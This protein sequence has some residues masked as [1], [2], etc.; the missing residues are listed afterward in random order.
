MKTVFASG[1]HFYTIELYGVVGV[2]MVIEALE[3]EGGVHA[4]GRRYG[5]CARSIGPVLKAEDACGAA[6]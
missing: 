4:I 2:Q 1:A 5:A 6:D 3:K